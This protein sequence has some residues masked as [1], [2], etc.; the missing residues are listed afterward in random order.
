MDSSSKQKDIVSLETLDENSNDES[1]RS[2]PTN[3]YEETLADNDLSSFNNNNNNFRYSSSNYGTT[4]STNNNVPN[5]RRSTASV[6]SSSVSS[7][8]RLSG[9]V[10]MT[11]L[12]PSIFSFDNLNNLK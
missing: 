10:F 1:I 8:K 5:L 3:F 4:N 6:A 9:G 12:T 7:A 11:N 2:S